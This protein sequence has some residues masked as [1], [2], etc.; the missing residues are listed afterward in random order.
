MPVVHRPLPPEFADARRCHDNS[1]CA[2]SGHR[3]KST[4]VPWLI[5]HEVVRRRLAG[6]AVLSALSFACAGGGPSTEGTPRLADVRIKLTFI[7]QFDQPVSLAFRKGDPTF[8]VAEKKGRIRAIRREGDKPTLVLDLSDRVSTGAE[9][10]LLGLAFSPD[11]KYLY[12]DFTDTDGDTRVIEYVFSKGRI[13]VTSERQVLAVD[14]PFENHNGG[15]LVFGPDGYLYVGLGDGGS[16]GDPLHNGQNLNT[17][18]GKILRISPRPSGALAYGI[19]QTNPFV[20]RSGRDEI[21]VYGLRNPWRF[22]FDR[23]THD[24]YIG[25]AGES[26]W[27]EIDLQPASSRGGEN[28]GWALREGRH[29]LKKGVL[30]RDYVPPIYEYAHADEKCRLPGRAVIG[31]HVYRGS[32]I[33]PLRS[34]YIFSDYC[35][36]RL[37][38][39][40][41]RGGRV[42]EHR[43]LG[44][45]AGP[46]TSFGEDVAGEVYVLSFAGG[47]L[48]IDPA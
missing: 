17:L 47:L 33:P 15:G 24:M 26:S 13:N 18:L 30:P 45:E 22:S 10:G 29:R 36:G 28:Y 9:Q 11:G 44:I 2:S 5:H 23:T 1:A 7:A 40:V 25:D 20:G 6:L 27:E 19:P 16:G 37:R 14:Q 39:L 3:W 32:R 35:S 43:F 8:Y 41:Q 4:P 31:G 38:A 12:V 46:I 42:T 34:A 21:W 48:R